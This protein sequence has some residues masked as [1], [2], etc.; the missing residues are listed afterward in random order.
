LLD[1]NGARLE[2]AGPSIAVQVCN[3]SIVFHFCVP[4]SHFLKKFKI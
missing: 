3:Y 1:D 4:F 2:E